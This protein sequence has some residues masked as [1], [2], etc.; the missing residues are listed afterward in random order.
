M[1][2]TTLSKKRVAG[3][4]L[5]AVIVGLF[6]ALNRFPKLDAVGGDLDVVS[7]TTEQCFQGFC[8]E[9]ETGTGLLE[10]WWVFSVTYLR[11]VAIGM[12]FAFLVAGLAEAFL[13]PSGSVGGLASGGVF[14]RTV[15]GLAVGPVMNLCSACIVPVSTAFHRK[16]VGIE[17]T[18]AMVQS[19][20]TMNIP[21]LAMVFFVFTPMLGF[22][23]LFLAIIGALLLGPVVALA[24]RRRQGDAG[25]ETEAV[26]LVE[27]KETGS[28]GPVLAEASRDWMKASVGY[29]VRLGPMMVVAAFVSGLV[30]QWLSPETVS[31]YLGNNIA[32]I[33][34][35]ATFGILINVPLLFEIPLVALLLLFGMGTAPAATLLFTAAAGGP[36]TFWG[37]AKV[38]PKKAIATFAAATWILGTLGGLVVLGIGAFIWESADNLRVEAAYK[39]AA[40]VLMGEPFSAPITTVTPFTELDLP[41]GKGPAFIWNRRPGVAIF[42]YDRDGDLDFYI[43]A[44]QG[45]PN[46]LY[47]N[48]GR[49]NFQDVAEGAGVQA[50]GRNSTGVVACDLNNDGYQD[51]YV[52]SEGVYGDGLDFRSSPQEQGNKD[53]L[54]L[55]NGDGSFTDI[56]EA[57]FGHAVNLRSA[58]SIACADVDGDQ[59][60]DLYVGNFLDLD[61]RNFH[62]PWHAGNYNVL[63]RNNG[64]LTF[65]DVSEVA[66][67]KGTQILMRYPD[68][69]PV[70][71]EDPETGERF[72]GYDPTVTDREGNRV[73]DP[74]AQTHAVLFFDNDDDGDPDLWVANDGDRLHVY[75]NDSTPGNIRF[76]SVAGEMGI[77][78]VGAWMGFAL[79]DYDGDADLDVFVTN[80]GFHHRMRGRLTTPGGTCE[81][82][83]QFPWGSCLNSLLRNDGTRDVPGVG[84]VGRFV[85]V[86]PGTQVLPSPLMPPDSLN[87]RAVHPDWPVPTGLAAYDFGFGTTFFDYDNDG[88][89]DLYWLGSLEVRGEGPGGQA[90]SSAGRMLESDGHGAFRDI[91]VR[92]HLLDIDRVDYSVLDPEDPRFD[93]EAQRIRPWFHENGKG[94][95]HG[96]LNGDGFVDLI[97]TNSSGFVYGKTAKQPGPLY[98]WLNGGGENHWITLRLRG[99]MAIDG[100]GSNADGIGARVQVTTRP[101][102]ADQPLVQVQEALAGSSYLSMDSIDLEFGLGQADRVEQIEV[103][104]P[105]GRRQILTNV[106]LDQVLL[107]EEPEA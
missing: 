43:T 6:F 72:E 82:H 45:N 86:A 34:I 42:D 31:T 78:K 29:L 47:Q 83:D 63:Y 50:V 7:S 5:L 58:M 20:T 24:I 8:I 104:W 94:L 44:N 80:L 81:Y 77:D 30:I 19:S 105:S 48:E 28:W 102:G 60:L 98:I 99:R 3:I 88:D 21:A 49:G 22:S 91:T 59:W 100:T 13:F 71:Y 51:L 101:E 87:P 61:F 70:L 32:G 79:G 85:D 11:L 93:A 37:L 97:G 40:P 36:F 55:N 54:F 4:V 92:A 23:R 90:F 75:R 106:D 2:S 35:A 76:A 52:G 1:F 62:R 68:G 39:K 84:P 46:V 33:M 9:R 27:L 10:Q 15:K 41:P 73:G 57:A 14:K 95:A 74:T 26:E 16:G 66:G 96:D 38:M 17:G 53:L 107:I 56:T 65:T 67:V 12:G 69:S 64:D 103:L 89:Q 25:A 18:I